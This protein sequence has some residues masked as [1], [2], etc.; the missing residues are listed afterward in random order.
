MFTKTMFGPPDSYK[1]DIQSV[2]DDINE[3]NTQVWAQFHYKDYYKIS[4]I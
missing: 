1:D 3:L 2:R 4:K